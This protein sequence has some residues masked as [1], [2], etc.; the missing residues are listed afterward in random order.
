MFAVMQ[1]LSG[2]SL[3]AKP[4]WQSLAFVQFTLYYRIYKIAEFCWG[5]YRLHDSS[6]LDFYYYPPD[7]FVEYVD[8]YSQDS[9]DA[10][11]INALNDTC[12]PFFADSTSDPTT[13]LVFISRIDDGI[14]AECSQATAALRAKGVRLVLLALNPDLDTDLMTQLTGDRDT[15]QY[16]DPFVLTDPHDFQQWFDYTVGCPTEELFVPCGD[17]SGLQ[18]NLSFDVDQYWV[19]DYQRI[20]DF[21]TG[22][23]FGGWTHP[24]RI[25]T[26]FYCTWGNHYYSRNSFTS[27]IDLISI[28]DDQYTNLMGSCKQ[29]YFGD[30]AVNQVATAWNVMNGINYYRQAYVAFTGSLSDNDVDRINKASAFFHG[31]FTIVALNEEVKK[32]ATNAGL[33]VIDWSDPTAS[34]P[35]EWKQKFWAAFGCAGSPPNGR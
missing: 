22:D 28:I 12:L 16:W 13:L 1:D 15:V 32:N 7:D 34:A 30:N 19:P 24:E 5:F 17:Q 29:E 6:L 33:N 21:L 31:P 18:I 2:V 9:N 8:I 20:R 11:L 35:A 14:V 25:T 10:K 27:Y 4:F 3:N 23:F 26:Y